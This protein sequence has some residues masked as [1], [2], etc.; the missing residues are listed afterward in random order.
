M[1]LNQFQVETEEIH[2]QRNWSHHVED[3]LIYIS[4]W[5]S[6]MP[7][8]LPHFCGPPGEYGLSGCLILAFLPLLLTTNCLDRNWK[9]IAA[10]QHLH[11]E[12]QILNSELSSFPGKQQC[13]EEVLSAMTLRYP[14]FLLVIVSSLQLNY[15]SILGYLIHCQRHFLWITISGFQKCVLANRIFIGLLLFW[16]LSLVIYSHAI[17]MFKRFTE[18]PS[19]GDRDKPIYLYLPSLIVY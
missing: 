7:L 15:F 8:Y 17:F 10:V 9:W 3:F 2:I 5:E 4:A 19:F 11:G 12:D 16:F 6:W 13:K 1:H 14:L 18:A